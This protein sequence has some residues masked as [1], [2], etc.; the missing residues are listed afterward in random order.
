MASTSIFCHFSIHVKF[1]SIVHHRTTDSQ[2]QLKNLMILEGKASEPH[3]DAGAEDVFSGTSVER[4]H[5][6]FWSSCSP[7]FAVGS[8]EALGLSW[9]YMMSEQ[10]FLGFVGNLNFRNKIILTKFK[11]HSIRKMYLFILT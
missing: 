10:I 7:K 2:K 8:R 9:P 5:E 4:V 6:G 3:S 11:L 1:F